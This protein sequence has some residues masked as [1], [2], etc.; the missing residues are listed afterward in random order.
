MAPIVTTSSRKRRKSNSA[1]K[2]LIAL[3]VIAVLG[4]VYYFKSQPKPLQP[5]VT[6]PNTVTTATPKANTSI[7]TKDEA[8]TGKG[9]VGKDDAA[10]RAKPNFDDVVSKAESVT[11]P[12]NAVR[13]L[14]ERKVQKPSGFNGGAAEQYIGMLM[15]RSDSVDGPP[16]PEVSEKKMLTEFMIAITNDIIIYDDDDEKT[17]EFKEKVADVKNQ[18]AQIVADGGSITNALKEYENWIAENK[19]IRDSVIKEYKRLKAEVSQEAADE[20]I[21]EANK[22]LE[23]EGIETVNLGK[24]RIRNRAKHMAETEAPAVEE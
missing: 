22:E 12:T 17:V 2:V 14:P 23:A 3:I 9:T 24:E 13:V 4:G 16:M 10:V 5:D 15:S 6:K 19:Q 8:G 20:Y 7:V 1:P 11:E 18:L 21:V